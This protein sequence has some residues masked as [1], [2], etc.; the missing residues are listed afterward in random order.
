MKKT[1]T[2]ILM[3]LGVVLFF[4]F[5]ANGQFFNEGFESG[6]CPPANWTLDNPDGLTTFAATSSAAH[7]GTQS[8]F[9]DVYNM[10]SGE[11]GQ[12]DALITDVYNLTWATSTPALTFYY[13]YQMYS[14]PATY[15]T[16]DALSV[17]ASTDGGSTWN[18]IYSKS[19]NVLV[20]AAAQCDS[21][22]GFVPTSN[23][24]VMETVDI[25]SVATASGVQF[26]FEFMN[27]WENNFYIDDIMLSGGPTG[28]TNS[29]LETY[30]N[31][32]PNPSTGP[33][34]VDLALFS[35]GQT[36]ITVYNVVGEVVARESHNVVNP[37]RVK[38]D[39]STQP[40]GA[41]FV[42]VQ[43]EKGSVTRKLMLNK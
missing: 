24:W 40:N 36:E 8:A 30:I 23:E 13:A 28:I 14:D 29:D 20:T 26:K 19:G 37:K 33:V 16:A 32:Y 11:A 21:T 1:S 6:S 38:L 41:Y 3:S 42:K 2:L 9:L 35:L 10:T 31:V 34:N 39:L 15:T 27:D 4:S 12:A 18:S 22:Q 7:S 17:Y 5:N 25:S 43:T